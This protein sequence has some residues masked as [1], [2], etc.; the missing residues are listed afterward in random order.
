MQAH[1]PSGRST[2]WPSGLGSVLLLVTDA[3]LGVISTLVEGVV[4]ELVVVL[5]ACVFHTL[6]RSSAFLLASAS[7]SV[8]CLLSPIQTSSGNW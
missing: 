6:A 8:T 7:A 1:A 4:L 2:T 5:P 3:F